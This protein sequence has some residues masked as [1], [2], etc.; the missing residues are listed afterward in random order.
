MVVHGLSR[1]PQLQRW[2]TGRTAI[3]RARHLERDRTGRVG[4]AGRV[5]EVM[6]V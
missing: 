5:A 6:G 2:M 4:W 1:D 3:V